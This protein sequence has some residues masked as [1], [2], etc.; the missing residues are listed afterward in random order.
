MTFHDLNLNKPLLNALDDMGL[1]TPTPIQVKSFSTIMSGRDV[2][3]VAQ[4]GTGKTYAYLLPLLK[5]HKFS[6]EK[7]PRVLILVPTR[8]LVLQVV[9]EAQKLSEYISIRIVGVYGGTNINTQRLIV[10]EGVDMLVA[11]P[12]RL[13]DIAMSGSL[14]LKNVKKLVIDEVDQMLDLGFKPQLVNILEL[15]PHKRQ[16]LLFSATMTEAVEKIIHDFFNRPEKIEVDLRGT[17]VEKIDQSSYMVPNFF[18]KTNLLNYLLAKDADMTKV[19]VFVGTKRMANRLF[20]EIE[21]VYK[22]ELGI[23]HSNKAQN[24]RIKTVK[25]FHAGEIRLLIATEIIARGLDVSEVS[26]VINFDTP[27]IAENY[28]HRIGRTGRADKRGHAIS[29]FKEEEQ[30]YKTAIEEL[31]KREIPVLPL[32]EEIEVS[33]ELVPEEIPNSAGDI[34]YLPEI[35]L[36][37]QG[38]FHDKKEKN[39]KVNQAHLKRRARAIEK[40]KARRKKKQRK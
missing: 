19:L 22:E 26:H 17:P 30:E 34:N 8:E 3:G 38:A 40:K 15:I 21:A 10:E 24:F 7:H 35:N 33:D 16:N 39:K 31:M 32:P 14:R 28:I 2:I 18:T 9:E 23:I 11:T 4:T 37:S 12:G 5:F 1:E 29:F 36:S 27:D 6:K 13:Y 25:K 20:E